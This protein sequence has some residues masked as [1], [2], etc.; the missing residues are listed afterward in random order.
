MDVERT[1]ASSPLRRKTSST[2]LRATR[3]S[4]PGARSPDRRAR[5]C[6]PARRRGPRPRPM[7]GGTGRLSGEQQARLLA[8]S[9]IPTYATGG[10]VPKVASRPLWRTLEARL[11]R[12]RARRRRAEAGEVVSGLSCSGDSAHRRLVET[13]MPR[14]VRERVPRR[15]THFANAVVS[16]RAVAHGPEAE[17]A[18]PAAPGEPRVPDGGFRAARPGP[19]LAA[20]DA[21]RSPPSPGASPGG[22]GPG[23]RSPRP[24]RTNAR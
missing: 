24:S 5:C 18:A 22:S 10:Q 1:A 3:S 12:H 6:S 11:E 15:P 8:P 20:H 9:T 19:S 7:P 13:E 17:R 4:G 14:D 21:A 23:T 16:K 2:D